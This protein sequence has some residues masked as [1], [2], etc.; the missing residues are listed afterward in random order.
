MT[1][2][3]QIMRRLAGLL[4]RV[5]FRRIDVVDGTALPADGPVIVVANHVNGL[6][7]GMVLMAALRR[8]PRFLGKSTLFKI[9]PLAPLLHLAGVVPVHRAADGTTAGND[10]TF[11]TCRAL[12]AA[13]GTIGIFPEGISHDE[14]QLQPLRTGAARIG[15]ESVA[16]GAPDLVIVPVGL[17]YDEKA[18]F[19]SR[20]VVQVGPPIA[21]QPFV[22]E[23]SDDPTAAVRSLTTAIDR[24]LRVVG[25]D[26][27]SVGDEVV[28]NRAAD[29][30]VRPSGVDVLA[31]LDLV[32]RDRVARALSVASP[33]RTDEL[34]AL[35]DAYDADLALAGLDDA[36]VASMGAPGRDPVRAA[37]AVVVAGASAPIAAIGAAIH[38]VPYA[39][40]KQIAKRPRNEGMKATV[41]VLGCFASFLVVY[42]ILGVV[43]GRRR[44][45]TAGVAAAVAA[46][47][48]GYVALRFAERVGRIG[49]AVATAHRLRTGAGAVL[50]SLAD[51]RQQIVE[52]ADGV[53]RDGTAAI[54][55]R[56]R[57]AAPGELAG[58]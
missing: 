28:W 35:V 18:R 4:M 10:E 37:T 25:P 50:A 3:D 39:I 40:V 56:S 15:L 41:K 45:A 12:L 52:R 2:S 29:I 27:A 5:F 44:G 13:G 24:S 55:E 42:A 9:L 46:P 51:Q 20:A 8:Y 6:V 33:P 48:S 47:L 38:G 34:R 31:D 32:R 14:A 54:P 57:V 11:R 36:Q 58:H 1:V 16:D 21:V 26:F 53:L 43:V 17:H 49:G 30:V 19:R 22:D 23:T 7:D